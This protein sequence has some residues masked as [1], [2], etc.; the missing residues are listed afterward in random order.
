MKTIELQQIAWLKT[1]NALY[2]DVDGRIAGARQKM[3]NT[4]YGPEDSEH[5]VW[6]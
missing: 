3:I 1:R 4:L 2:D 5:T 6:F